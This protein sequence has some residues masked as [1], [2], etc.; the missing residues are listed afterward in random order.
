MRKALK[1]VLTA[2]MVVLGGTVVVL[3]LSLLEVSQV[4]A[5]TDADIVA[6]FFPQRLIDESVQDFNAG[7]PPLFQA[8]NYTRADL[9]G[10]GIT[11]FIV[12]AYSNGFSGDVR[13][14]HTQGQSATLV[15]EP[16][17]RLLA[18]IYPTIE[19]LD[20]NGDGR[21]EVIVSF[22]S[23]RGRSATWV[24]KWSNGHLVLF[25]PSTTDAS[26]DASTILTDAAFVDLNGD[27]IPEIV[28]PPELGP[29]AQDETELAVGPFTIFQ[30][31]TSGGG[32]ALSQSANFFGTFLRSTGAPVTASATF[33]GTTNTRAILTVINGVGTA[34]RVSSA[35]ISLNGQIV[36]SSNQ[37]NQKISMI[38]VPLVIQD[39][40]MIQVSLK[41]APGSLLRIVV[42][43]N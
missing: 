4:L 31:N 9:N 12:A 11:D 24:F 6:Q 43:P 13:V 33:A 25:G 30:L 10:I 38:K 34:N 39:S 23:A 20:L 40:N 19:L 21:S 18:G 1:A 3:S 16:N 37:L 32:Y 15:D 2:V 5:A 26:G 17:L 22:S 29:L 42:A 35:V 27:G 14:L 8:S 41:S 28:N 7:G 36:I